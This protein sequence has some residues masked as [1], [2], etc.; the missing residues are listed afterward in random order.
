MQM[1]RFLYCRKL[2]RVVEYVIFVF[3]VMPPISVTQSSLSLTI[4]GRKNTSHTPK[5]KS[6]THTPIGFFL[7]AA[8][9]NSSSSY[10]ISGIFDGGDGVASASIYALRSAE[11]L[12]RIVH[13]MALEVCRP[14]ALLEL[15]RKQVHVQQTE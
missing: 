14:A 12:H 9:F 3:V 5:S 6:Q 10:G 8:R 7:A 1:C 11:S 4:A 13:S 2:K 15:T